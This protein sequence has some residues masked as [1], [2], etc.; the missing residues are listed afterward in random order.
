[1]DLRTFLD[2][3]MGQAAGV[4]QRLDAAG[5]RVHPGAEIVVAADAAGD[6]GL[7]E[8]LHRYAALSPLPGAALDGAHGRGRGR[9][10]DPALAGRFAVDAV[11]LDQFE[12]RIG[13]M[14]RNLDQAFR[15]VAAEHPAQLVRVMLE[16]GNH[17]AAVTPGGAP[18][19]L[20]GIQ[21]ADTRT[22]AG[23][24]QRG[25]QPGVA[26]TDDDHVEAGALL[27]WRGCRAGDG[28]GGPE[29]RRQWHTLVAHATP[30]SVFSRRRRKSWVRG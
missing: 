20:A 28:C 4:A 17:L 13:G 26:G 24:V 21:H 23:Q 14:A 3:C 19:R 10:L 29:R 22:C 9:W 25:D 11:L 1:M 15:L 5:T 27:Q 7:V 6:A 16:A 12:D 2:R 8:H 30:P 18:A